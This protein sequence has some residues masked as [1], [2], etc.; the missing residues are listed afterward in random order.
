MYFVKGNL[1]VFL[2][3]YFIILFYFAIKYVKT[4]KI[5]R[6]N[7]MKKKSADDNK[8]AGRDAGHSKGQRSEGS[9]M[10]QSYRQQHGFS[11]RRH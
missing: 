10:I 7:I 6:F 8:I 4:W 2:L 3:L 9:L 1:L 11:W 5:A